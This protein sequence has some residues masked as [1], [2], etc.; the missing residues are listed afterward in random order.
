MEARMGSFTVYKMY[1]AEG[2]AIY[3]GYTERGDVRI[4]EHRRSTPWFAEV[5]DIQF[6]TFA[7]MTDATARETFL[8]KS[9]KPKYNISTREYRKPDPSRDDY[10]VLTPDEIT[11]DE[12]MC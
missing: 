8:I 11:F 6:E 3:V 12:H 5:A 7:V 1:D 9:L 4:N 2:Q 10:F